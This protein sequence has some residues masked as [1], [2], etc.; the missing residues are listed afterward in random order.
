MKKIIILLAFVF[1]SQLSAT[2]LLGGEI[3]WKCQSNGKYQFTLVLYRDCGG[4]SLGTNSQT[5]A[6]NAGVYISA[7][8]VGTIDIVPSS[9]TGTGTCAGASGGTGYMQKYIYQSGDIALIGVPPVGGWN[10]SWSSCCRPGSITN[11]NTGGYLLRSVMYPFTPP[12]ASGPI[13]AGTAGNPS[14]FDNSPNFLESPSVVACQGTDITYNSYGFDP[15][16]DSIYFSFAAPAAGTAYPGTP[17]TWNS[18]Y[19]T[20]SPM[21]SGTAST[22]ANLSSMGEL[23]FNS[24]LTGSYALC[25]RVEEFRSGQLIGKVFRDIPMVVRSCTQPTGLC[26]ATSGTTKPSLDITA[27]NAS[28]SLIPIPNVNGDTTSYIIN[29]NVGDTV[30]LSLSSLDSDINPNC[31]SQLIT[32]RASG[33]DS[34]QITSYNPG[35]ILSNTG[36][37]WIGFNWVTDSADYN[38]GSGYSNIVPYD[39]YFTFNDDQ[40]P[41]NQVN[42][43]RVRINLSYPAVWISPKYCLSLGDSI[44]LGFPTGTYT[45]YLWS[46]GDTINS[47]NVHQTGNYSVIVQSASGGTDTLSTIVTANP[48]PVIQSP[49]K[50]CPGQTATLTVQNSYASYLWGPGFSTSNSITTGAGTFWLTVF[51]SLGCFGSDTI[52]IEEI[53]PYTD[54]PQVCIVTNDT[55]GHNQIIWE[56]PSKLGTVSYNI[57]RAGVIGYTN[58]GSTGVNQLSEF[59]DTSV[60]PGLQPHKYYVTL[61]DSCGNESGS[62]TTE[63]ST[64]HLQSGLG[65]VGEVNLVWTSY[66]GTTPLYYKIYRKAAS[67]AAF[68]VL[69]SVN[70]MTNTYTDFNPPTGYTKYQI[71]AVMGSGCNSSSKTG[72]TSSLSNSTA[73]NTISIKE[74]GISSIAISPNPN[75]GYFS[76]TVDQQQ[77]GSVY[78]IIDNL[79]RLIDKG[80]ITEQNQAFD[81][82]DKPKGV[83]RIQVSNENI[84]KTLSVVIQ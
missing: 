4:I 7:A 29:I 2:H 30:Q 1:S 33:T 58:I 10:F 51:D 77:V 23:T 54:T 37:N 81:L 84:A 24:N 60:N 8:Y 57:Y 66:S 27:L 43:K 69:D 62:S 64:V 72:V 68:L 79:G 59:I 40:S 53:I 3:T 11:T 28:S 9:Y 75:T 80:I 61:I 12:G 18:G 39:Y 70:V 52:S 25:T 42:I 63:H 83:Y 32:F 55:S 73:Q 20:S 22:A 34:T 71:A 78:R 36:W 14:C 5:I 26:L 16:F 82:S 50:I 56:R 13:S 21:P 31:A 76:I 35:G 74:D 48:T 65:T 67:N 38:V 17:V 41:I 46:T 6:N 19:T 15:D 47:I 44:Q 45:S 49:A